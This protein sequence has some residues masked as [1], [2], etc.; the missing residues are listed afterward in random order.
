MP[1]RA[2]T[3]FDKLLRD[4]HSLKVKVIRMLNDEYPV[5]YDYNPKK[6]RIRTNYADPQIAD[7]RTRN[8]IASR[9]SRQRKKFQFQVMQYSVDYDED[10]NEVCQK[11]LAWLTGMIL[12]MEQHYICENGETPVS[13]AKLKNIRQQCGLN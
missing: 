2:M 1:E 9:R 7:D 8:N 11:Q 10:E 6:S 5:S 13:F 12:N 3:E 4:A